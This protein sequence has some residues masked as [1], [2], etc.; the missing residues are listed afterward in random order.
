MEDLI[1]QT[2][3]MKINL[4]TFETNVLEFICKRSSSLYNQAIYFVRR[5]HEM[6]HPG[7]RLNVPYEAMAG[8]LKDE[9]NYRMLYS[10]VAQQTLKSVAEAFKSYKQL[11]SL[12]MEGQLK[13]EP[14]LPHFRKKGG[15]YPC[16]YPSQA[17]TFDLE[18]PFIRI[19][20]GSGLHELEGVSELFI[21]APTGI[22]PEQIIELSI[23]PRN[24]CFY[25]AYA[26]KSVP[27][28]K[29]NLDKSNALGI[30]HGRDNW[31]TC[32]SNIGTSLIVDGLHLKSLNRWYN[33]QI[34]TI[35]E[36]KPEGFWNNRLA[37]ITE[38]RNRQVRDAV[39]KAARLVIDHCLGNDIGT[40]V[41]GWNDGQKQRSNMSKVNNQS[42]IQIPTA[43]LKDRIAHLCELHGINFVETEEAYTSKGSFVDGDELPKIGEKPIGYK[44]SGKRVKRGL[45]RTGEKNWYINADC[46]AAA[47]MLAKV[48]TM[49]GLELSGVSRSALAAPIRLRLWH[50]SSKTPLLSATV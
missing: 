45:Y 44:P 30:D 8:N 48:C 25:A 29:L 15:L 32:V 13:N 14:R 4:P 43:R 18:T 7:N 38:K 28:V 5:T 46:N 12:W 21:P 50:V 39:N 33:K 16:T 3:L 40:V 42:F 23:I 27:P 6:T 36:G 49:L 17:L 1:V 9:W 11:I 10:Q 20:L 31:L 26:Y 35:K 47:N 22:R 37:V 34:S 19:P 24:G 41:F 2:K